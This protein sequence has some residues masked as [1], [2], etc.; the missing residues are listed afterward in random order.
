MEYGHEYGNI[1]CTTQVINMSRDKR[2]ASLF[3]AAAAMT[4][5]GAEVAASTHND[6]M[7]PE[8]S[9]VDFIP[10]SHFHKGESN[11]LI[12]DANLFEQQATNMAKALARKKHKVF[13]KKDG[14]TMVVLDKTAKKTYRLHS[15]NLEDKSFNASSCEA[16]AQLFAKNGNVLFFV[17][18]KFESQKLWAKALEYYKRSFSVGWKRELVD[19]AEPPEPM[20]QSGHYQAT[21]AYF[22][23]LLGRNAEALKYYN[24]AIALSPNYSINYTNRAQLYLKMAKPELAE[25]DIERVNQ[26]AQNNK[27]VETAKTGATSHMRERHKIISSEDFDE[28]INTT[29]DEIKQLEKQPMNLDKASV[30]LR[31]ARMQKRLGHYKEALSDYQA[32]TKY[33]SYNP[34]LVKERRLTERLLQCGS[35]PYGDLK[36]LGP[37]K[38]NVAQKEA[39]KPALVS[40]LAKR[41]KGDL[42]VYL[43]TAIALSRAHRLKECEEQVENMLKIEPRNLEFLKYR[44]AVAESMDNAANVEKYSTDYLNRIT[45]GDGS[46]DLEYAQRIYTFRAQAEFALAHYD[47]SVNDYS[48]LLKLD[49]HS[50]E[51][52]RGRADCYTKLN[53]LDLA[54]ADLETASKFAGQ[55]Q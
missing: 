8:P 31:R 2:I 41:S 30:Y 24:R 40:D 9:V 53:K 25:K 13:I 38:Y 47:K 33:D 43:A 17:S 50:A 4:L 46:I 49:P 29:N 21:C 16:L 34:D 48:T 28:S 14:Q 15:Q 54:K 37:A 20:V 6:P 19:P 10:R 45:A 44:I 12:S 22:E 3:L 7:A 42:R 55:N 23:S 51:A 11:F 18:R 27:V 36:T 1:K 5:L 35:P 39:L 52:Y 32:L 26:L